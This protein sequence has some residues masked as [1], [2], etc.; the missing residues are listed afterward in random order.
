LVILNR[1]TRSAAPGQVTTARCVRRNTQQ[2]SLRLW[3]RCSTNRWHWNV[4]RS[5]KS[6]Q[7][8]DECDDRDNKQATGGSYPGGMYPT[9]SATHNLLAFI[10]L[11]VSGICFRFHSYKFHSTET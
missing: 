2:Q 3:G 6:S 1:E 7:S 9:Y 8:P 11:A 5:L 4:L 10:E